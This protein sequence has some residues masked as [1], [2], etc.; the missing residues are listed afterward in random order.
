MPAL[1]R[2][3]DRAGMMNSV[4]I[5]MPFMDWR[6]V[7]YVFS[8]PIQSKLGKGFT[9]LILREAMKG[10]MNEDLRTRTYKVGVASPVEF[11][12]N[13]S[14][15]TW[16]IDN[17]RDVKLKNEI[18]ANYQKGKLCNKDV[19]AVWKHLNIELMGRK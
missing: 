3:F 14:L 9:K 2:N 10:K 1:L 11:W 12:F 13:G 16:V 8:L 15:K 7:T 5:R 19:N 17:I 18:I 4:E 6:L